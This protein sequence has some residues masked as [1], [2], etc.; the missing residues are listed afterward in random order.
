MLLLNPNGNTLEYAASRGFRSNALQHSRLH[1][2]EGHAGRAALE[3]YI[4]HIPN[5]AEAENGFSRSPQLNAENFIAYYGV[6]LVAKGHVKG[7]LEI[8]HRAPPDPDQE[9]LDFL[10][11]LAVRAAIA[12]DNA[13]LFDNLQRLNIDLILAYDTTIEGWS[14]ALD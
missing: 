3:R 12:I 6:P 11:A 10:E 8:F 7:I 1:L 4:V 5:L 13:S 9:W 14:R 2:G